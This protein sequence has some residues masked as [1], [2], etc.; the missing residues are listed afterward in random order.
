[1]SIEVTV[2]E[3]RKDLD[4]HTIPGPDAADDFLIFPAQL[5]LLPG[6]EVGV[7]VRWIG[8]PT[9]ARERVFTV[10]TREVALPKLAGAETEPPDSI[11]IA[12]T[13][14]LNY[15]VRVYV[16]PPGARPRVVVE[17]VAERAPLPAEPEA[18]AAPA[19][20]EVI[21]ANEG[22][23]HVALSARA[24]VL[25][26]AVSGAGAHAEPSIQLPTREIPAL[27]PHLLAGDRRRVIIPRPPGL[28]PGPVH[29]S[30][31]E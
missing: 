11:R 19:Q 31:P 12:V 26:P 9:L 25:T 2:Q 22:N 18:A 10:V 20:L 7:Q 4:G 29:V 5:V 24:L 14:Q 16:T 28:P 1:V 27:K 23:A 21:L 30:L 17:S 3:H 8:A 15:E 6:D 13:V